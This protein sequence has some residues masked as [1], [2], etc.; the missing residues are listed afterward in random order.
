MHGP[1]HE[2]S[3]IEVLQ[4][5]ERGRRSGIVRVVGPDAGAPRTLRMHRGLIAAVEP[6]ADDGAVHRALRR[7]HLVSEDDPVTIIATAEREEL[8]DRLA[9][10]A[11]ET[12]MR[13]TRGRFDFAD[14][15][16]SA[17][18][19][20][21]SPDA[22]V[23]ALIGDESQRVELAAELHDWHAVPVMAAPEEIAEG[24]P[25]ALTALDWRILDAVDG[26][27][28]IAAVAA[29][30]DEPLGMVGSHVR[31][32]AQAAII[33]IAAPREQATLEA[34]Q[35]LEA[36]EYDA[37]AGRLRGRVDNAPHDAEAWR[38]LGLAE[39]GAGRFD[40]AIEAWIAWREAAPARA[41]EADALIQAARTMMEA[42]L[43][44]RE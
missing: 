11:V 6:D 20:A 8:R 27:R 24:P 2:I 12:M 3:L 25:L 9:R 14:G 39:V 42:L 40:A 19:L 15:D 34:R 44:S 4:L 18:P 13:W 36:G 22:L 37:A 23:L 5:L 26:E 21:W 10:D 28:D 30:L 33:R 31:A 16:T 41:R 17:G 7:R 29:L 35:A 1:L 32:L 38:S 43:D